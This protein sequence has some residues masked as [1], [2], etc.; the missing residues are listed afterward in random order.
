MLL[1]LVLAFLLKAQA[2]MVGRFTQV[3]GRVELLKGGNLPALSVK[4]GD[5]VE[6]GDAIRTKS[7]SKAQVQFVDD[8]TLNIAP[9]SR[10]AIEEYLYDAPQKHRKAVLQIFRGL[11]HTVVSRILQVEKPDFILKTHTGILGVRGTST[12]VSLAPFF[13][14]IYNES[15]KIAARNILTEIIGEVILGPMEFSRIGLDL[16]PTLPM[17][18]SKED[19][20]PLQNRFI[21]KPGA[22][23]AA[24]VSPAGL[25]YGPS[26]ETL[27]AAPALSPEAVPVSQTQ[28]NM[29][30]NLAT[31]LYI[32]PPL[33]PVSV[34]LFSQSFSGI[35]TLTSNSP[36]TVGNYSG[37]GSGSQ[38]GVYPHVFSSTF[39]LT[40]TSSSPTFA[41]FNTGTIN[42]TSSG[43]VTGPSGGTLTGNMTMTGS[44]SGGTSFN[45]TGPVTLPVS[46]NLTYSPSGSFNLGPFSGSVTGSVTQTPR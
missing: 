12:Y 17:P 42:M 33:P 21:I 2:A 27:P 3:E 46:G 4:V 37:S 13:T 26:A 22:P 41:S 6:P 45:L 25:V 20:M 35:Y 1:A 34:F 32:P 30:N 23:G 8:T 31:A 10:V 5:L 24:A 39:T 28:I 38:T 14:D 16:P 18:I 36:F 29:V 7:L 44:T 15:G 9:E 43:T 19:L 11:V 40:A